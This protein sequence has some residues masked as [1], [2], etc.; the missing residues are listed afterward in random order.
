MAAG[1]PGMV[2][3]LG[4]Q[5]LRQMYRYM[6]S[7]NLPPAVAKSHRTARQLQ[8]STTVLGSMFE[9]ISH[10]TP[11]N[12]RA[13][14]LPPMQ[15]GQG[16]CVLAWARAG[17]KYGLGVDLGLALLPVRLHVRSTQRMQ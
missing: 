4:G 16:A 15:W 6:L 8:E 11:I 7:R 3:V 5:S 2:A 1:H 13:L 12:R 14:A 9:P 10:V 17:Y